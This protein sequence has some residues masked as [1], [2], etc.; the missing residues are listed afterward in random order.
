[1]YRNHAPDRRA[2]ELE[3]AHY[4]GAAPFFVLAA[5][6]H[7]GIDDGAGLDPMMRERRR[8]RR[9]WRRLGTGRRKQVGDQP[10][11]GRAA[12]ERQMP[13]LGIGVRRSADGQLE[14]F[15]DQLTRHRLVSEKHAN[16]APLTDRGVEVAPGALTHCSLLR[17]H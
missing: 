10:I 2:E 13:G 12:G 8:D 17:S 14:G 5:N 16:G 11:T 1:V 9:G 4:R 3:V 7:R 15:V 6:A